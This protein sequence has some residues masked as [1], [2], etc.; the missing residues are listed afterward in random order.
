VLLDGLGVE[1]HRVPVRVDAAAGLYRSLL[2]GRKVLVVLDNAHDAAQ[3][4]PLLPGHPTYM[5]RIVYVAGA[6]Y[7]GLVGL[8][9]WQ[10]LRAEPVTRPGVA[11]SVTGGLLLAGTVV[12]TV[13][14]LHG[15]R[16][17]SLGSRG[18]HED[19]HEP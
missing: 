19:A 16:H 1:A 13:W 9:L 8:L 5:A 7:L 3:V 12:V 15:A 10:A 11:T 14:I 17:G 4:R 18:N 2:A 6:T